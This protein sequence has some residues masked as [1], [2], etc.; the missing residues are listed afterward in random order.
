MLITS[1]YSVYYTMDSILLALFYWMPNSSELGKNSEEIDSSTFKSTDLYSSLI[2]QSIQRYRMPTPRNMISASI[3][4]NKR[5]LPADVSMPPAKR[6]V[7]DPLPAD[8]H[9]KQGDDM[10]D[11]SEDEL[12]PLPMSMPPTEQAIF[13]STKNKR[14]QMAG[15]RL[16]SQNSDSVKTLPR[17]PPGMKTPPRMTMNSQPVVTESF[18]EEVDEEVK[19][20]MLDLQA[21]ALSQALEINKR[22]KAQLL[23]ILARIDNEVASQAPASVRMLLSSGSMKCIPPTQEQASLQA[24]RHDSLSPLKQP[25]KMQQKKDIKKP[26]P[27]SKL[28][29]TAVSVQKPLSNKKRGPPTETPI[30]RYYTGEDHIPADIRDLVITI[31]KIKREAKLGYPAPTPLREVE[32]IE[33]RYGY[34]HPPCILWDWR[35]DLRLFSARMWRYLTTKRG[36]IKNLGKCDDKM[37]VDGEDV[38]VE[39]DTEAGA[40][41]GVGKTSA[42]GEESMQVELE[43]QDG[44][45]D[46]MQ[47][48]LDAELEI[49]DDSPASDFTGETWAIA[50]DEEDQESEEE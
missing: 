20:P 48:A 6:M 13:Q 37:Q 3:T 50:E 28:E 15:K 12:E 4:G 42:A 24:A 40:E 32:G 10:S 11:S 47:A 35:G 22:G 26:A 7:L 16:R 27:V 21:I 14:I 1:T 8:Y 36:V 29:A 25:N 39:A 19:E 45:S 5:T 23:T 41:E 34:I 49:C 31:K 9:A 44:I 18:E 17:R 38:D 2:S 43:D 46:D 33:G 30:S